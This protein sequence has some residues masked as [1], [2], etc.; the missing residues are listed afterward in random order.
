MKT[1]KATH[2]LTKPNML[3]FNKHT[4]EQKLQCKRKIKTRHYVPYIK[5]QTFRTDLRALKII[6]NPP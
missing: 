1:I 4:M 5:Q 2:T 3:I 6:Q